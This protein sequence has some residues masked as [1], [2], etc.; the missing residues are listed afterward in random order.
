MGSPL[1]G[2][3]N[4]IYY[5]GLGE[6]QFENLDDLVNDGLKTMYLDLHAEELCA[7]RKEDEP[8]KQVQYEAQFS[9]TLCTTPFFAPQMNFRKPY[10]F[11]R[12]RLIPVF[13][14]S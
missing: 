3:P 9:A 10:F 13:A 11:P 7:M 8:G 4:S 12:D 1:L 2:L 14:L 6:T 5:F